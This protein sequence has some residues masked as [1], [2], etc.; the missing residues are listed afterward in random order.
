VF[1]VKCASLF[2]KKDKMTTVH[3]L[4]LLLLHLFFAS[5]SA[6][7]MTA[8]RA[9]KFLSQGAGYPSYATDSYLPLQK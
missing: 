7:F 2:S 6:D 3:V 9:K 1:S 4:R 5:N 8:R